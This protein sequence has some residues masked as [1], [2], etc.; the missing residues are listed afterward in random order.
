MRAEHPT[1]GHSDIARWCWQQI[2]GEIPSGGKMDCECPACMLL[3]KTGKKLGFKT[4]AGGR[5]VMNCFRGCEPLAVAEALSSAGSDGLSVSQSASGVSGRN[6]NVGRKGVHIAGESPSHQIWRLTDFVS[7][8]DAAAKYLCGR[9]RIDFSF[10]EGRIGRDVRFVPSHH[11]EWLAY[12]NVMR[13]PKVWGSE[14]AAAAVFGYRPACSVSHPML[15]QYL[16]LGEKTGRRD[17]GGDKQK[18]MSR[19]ELAKGS[20]CEVLNFERNGVL[21]LAESPVSAAAAAL[22]LKRSENVACSVAVS[23]YGA[24]GAKKMDVLDIAGSLEERLGVAISDFWWAAD[25]DAAGTS[26]HDTAWDQGC[27]VLQ[28]NI[29]GRDAA[30]DWLS[31]LAGDKKFTARRQ[32]I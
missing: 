30:D 6:F 23:V 29:V 16:M 32:R 19:G 8:G 3:G 9:L 7:D 25:G 17:F 27:H 4:A 14:R 28:S 22:V 13:K 1:V 24:S 15:V 12:H 18:A 2:A 21:V 26:A 5:V 11:A 20:V 10:L 31:F